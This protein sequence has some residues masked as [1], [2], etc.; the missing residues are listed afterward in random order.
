MLAIGDTVLRGVN[1]IF[2]LIALALTGSLAAGHNNSQVSFSVFA[3]AFAIL[4]SSFYGVLAYF[5]EAFAWPVVLFTFDLLNF[6]FTFAGATAIAANI[7]VHSCKNQDYINGN[8]IIRGSSDRCRKAQGLCFFLYIPAF[9]FIV[10]LV[11]SGLSMAQGGMF[12]SKRG[13][14]YA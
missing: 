3:A 12:S 6:V 14:S 1:F 4:T 10:S 7:R 11:F 13:K 8:S 5:I 9:I 2:L